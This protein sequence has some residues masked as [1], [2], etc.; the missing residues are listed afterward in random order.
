M[1]MV[2]VTV[3]ISGLE[4]V[5]FFAVKVVGKTGGSFFLSLHV[6]PS[7]FKSQMQDPSSE[8]QDPWP[9]HVAFLVQKVLQVE[10]G[11]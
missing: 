5:T 10:T 6:S 8:K 7:Q 1:L 11:K 9:E 4:Y 2:A 3:F